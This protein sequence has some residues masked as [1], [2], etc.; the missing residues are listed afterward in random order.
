MMDS[1]SAQTYVTFQ[2]DIDFFLFLPLLLCQA[3][4]WLPWHLP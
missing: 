1:T 4:C 3:S 2:I